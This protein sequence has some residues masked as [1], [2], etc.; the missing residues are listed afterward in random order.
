MTKI[1]EVAAL[2][3]ENWTLSMYGGQKKGDASGQ[4]E[5]IAL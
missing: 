1:L 5:R 2:K 3:P 4:P